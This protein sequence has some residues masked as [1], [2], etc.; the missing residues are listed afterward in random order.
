MEGSDGMKINENLILLNMNNSMYSM[1]YMIDDA[2][3]A[4]FQHY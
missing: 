4:K 2:N 3:Y 1:S